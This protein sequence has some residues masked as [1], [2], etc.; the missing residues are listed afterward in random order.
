MVS[1]QIS[2]SLMAVLD[3]PDKAF[4]EILVASNFE[5]EKKEA[6]VSPSFKLQPEDQP[7]ENIG[8][9][10]HHS[11]QDTSV[12]TENQNDTDNEMNNDAPTG[13]QTPQPV[14]IS[15]NLTHP[16]PPKKVVFGNRGRP[17]KKQSEQNK[18]KRQH[19][20]EKHQ[21]EEEKDQKER[22]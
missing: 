11:S 8:F 21:I 16:T 5:E 2:D 17:T 19:L 9:V 4:D 7:Q 14:L 18:L 1:P 6:P 22:V 12:V 10:Q 3:K 20:L 15:I 13:V